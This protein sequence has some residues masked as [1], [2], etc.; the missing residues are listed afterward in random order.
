MICFGLTKAPAIG[1]LLICSI[2]IGPTQAPTILDHVGVPDLD[3]FG[4]ERR[5]DDMASRDHLLRR[6]RLD[7]DPGII[8]NLDIE[9]LH[10]RSRGALRGRPCSA[11]FLKLRFLN[12]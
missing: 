4:L 2:G 6:S 1:D 7:R 10:P 9:R 3:A 5:H 11:R 12:F 8:R